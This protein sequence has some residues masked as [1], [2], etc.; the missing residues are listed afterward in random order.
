MSDATIAV[1]PHVAAAAAIGSASAYDTLHAAA[2]ANPDEFWLDQ[3]AQLLD[4]MRVPTRG[5]EANP[6]DAECSWFGDGTLNASV[7][8]VDRHARATPAHPAI[9]W[10]GNDPG[11]RR[12]LTFA[13]LQTAVCR[14]ANVL[15]AHGVR[16]GD[17]V[18]IYLP[19]I[20]ELAVAMLA[21]ARIGAPHSV[22][23][24][25]FSAEALR[26]RILDA[27]ARVVITADEGVRGAR[28][29]PLKQIVDDALDHEG[30]VETV[31]VARRTGADVA[32][33]AG[34]DLWLDDELKKQRGVCPPEPMNAEDP[35]FLLYTSGSTGRPKGVLHTTGGYLVYAAATFGW[36]FGVQP[37][38]VHFCAAD[39]GW[40]TG[41]TYIVYG[42]LARGVTT[43]M[44]ESLPTFPDAGRYW[45]EIDA[46]GA[47]S[48][49][50]APTALRAL[51]REGD[52]WVRA[53]HRRSLRILGTVG[54]PINP[55]VWRWYH[56]VVG[57]GRC[58]VVD[59]WWQTETGGVLLTTL[60]GAHASVPGAAGFP[61]PGIRPVLLSDAGAVTEGSGILCLEGS[62]PG[63]ARTLYNDHARFKETYWA[64]FPGR[65][66]TGDGARQDELGYWWITGRVD[67]VL[68]VSGH[69]LGTAE[70]ESALVAHPSVAE[71][72]V[73]G[74]PHDLRGTGILAFVILKP[75]WGADVASLREKVR[76]MI[77]PF[78]SP[79]RIIAVPGLPKTRSGKIMRRILRKIGEGKLD[80]LGDTSTLAE[81]GVVADI[82]G[83]LTPS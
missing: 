40:V 26:G 22:V 76:E 35:L 62:W 78:A 9:V 53:G 83:R 18:C 68:N 67:D 20:P 45:R 31:L 54:E 36:I 6:L 23:F 71:A 55:D 65:Y 56:D 7:E 25:G 8:C 73:V 28:R 42:P 70:I 27:G 14:F 64:P 49:Y 2:L 13:E 46:V 48:F 63:Q 82:V 80:E 10:I 30:P 43:V 51:L 69:R 74:F 5:V 16:K 50:T 37:G 11:D 17:R 77:G 4:W 60:P 79:D 61:L 32:M 66:L 44:F 52:E 58:A 19:M 12:T 39:C 29:I 57:E 72:A 3:A 34:R 75:G 47:T 21:C 33:C 81:P 1:K 15:R 59:T 41:H 38:D 24:A